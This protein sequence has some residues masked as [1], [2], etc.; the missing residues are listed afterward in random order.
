MTN[1]RED[2]MQADK[3]GTFHVYARCIRRCFLLGNDE[4]SGKDYSARKEWIPLRLA[5]LRKTFLIDIYAYAVMSNHYHLILNNRPDLVKNLSSDEIGT[6]WLLLHPTASMKSEKREKPTA[7]E[8]AA[9]INDYTLE[10]IQSRLSDISWFMRELNQHIAVKANRDEGL[11]GAFFDGRFKSQYLAD[12]FAILTCMI[13]VDLNCVRAKVAA[14]IEDSIFTSGYDRMTSHTAQLNLNSL[15]ETKYKDEDSLTYHQKKEIKIQ[16]KIIK[17]S[18]W[19]A[20]LAINKTK[21]EPENGAP[22]KINLLPATTP[23]P[24]LSFTVEKYL[25]LLDLTGRTYHKNKPGVISDKFAPILDSMG[26]QQKHWMLRIKNY[27]LW[28][29]RVIGPLASLADKLI[30]TKQKWFKGVKLWENP[31]PKPTPI[32]T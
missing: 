4:E 13:Y 18:S 26:F 9:L 6:R 25:K 29:Y 7:T 17:K 5:V 15:E 3:C 27:G 11:T 28:Y 20:P 12:D 16:K 24:F 31:K 2:F 22:K 19:L 21:S 14:S 1:A 30:S 23:T 8:I 10:E 32:L